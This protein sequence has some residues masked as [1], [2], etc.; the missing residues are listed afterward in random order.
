L[1]DNIGISLIYKGF[2]ILL[3]A[4][5]I[6]MRSKSKTEKILKLLQNI[7]DSDKYY[8][9]REFNRTGEKRY[10]QSRRFLKQRV[11]EALE[12]TDRHTVS[13]WINLL[14]AKGYLENPSQ[15][16]PHNKT[17][18]YINTVL[19]TAYILKVSLRV[20]HDGALPSPLQVPQGSPQ[21]NKPRRDPRDKFLTH[22]PHA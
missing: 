11:M 20:M 19:I 3:V 1:A 10:F 15:D 6:E 2:V 8:N 14:E 13:G 5:E 9:K 12:I 16:T 21:L 22:H 18:Y 4:E 17:K 7:M